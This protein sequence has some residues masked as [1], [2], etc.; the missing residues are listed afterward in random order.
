MRHRAAT[1]DDLRRLAMWLTVEEPDVRTAIDQALDTVQSVAAA[2]FWTEARAS[3][4]CHEEAPFGTRGPDDALPLVINGAIDLVYRTPGGWRLVDYKT[5]SDADPGMLAAR[6]GEQVRAYERAW[7]RV[8]RETVTSAVL[9]VRR[10]S[11]SSP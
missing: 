11:S 10:G 8:T 6:Y 5:D 2:S 9:P 3:A 1:R 4:E 7:G